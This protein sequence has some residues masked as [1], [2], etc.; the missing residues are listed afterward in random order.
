MLMKML[1]HKLGHHIRGSSPSEFT[2]GL[3]GNLGKMNLGSN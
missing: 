3:H 2:N 1:E